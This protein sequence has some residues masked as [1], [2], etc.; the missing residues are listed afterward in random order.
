MRSQLALLVGAFTTLVGCSQAPQ[1]PSPQ[2]GEPTL[3]VYV[4]VDQLR[5]DLLDRYAAAFDGGFRRL[6]DEGMV[7]EGASHRHST[8]TT[9]VGHATLSTGVV[10]ARHGLNG[11]SWSERRPDGSLVDVY[12]V[13]DSTAPIV[14]LPG[15]PGRSPANLMRDGLADWILER[16]PAA[17]VVSLSAKDRAAIPMAG[18]ARGHVYWIQR[19][20]GRFVTSTHYRE[21]YPGWVADFNRSRMPL[22]LGDSVWQQSTPVGIREL[23]RP[24]PASYEGDGIHTTFPHVRSQETDGPMPYAQWNWSGG[25]P[26]PDR[27]VLELAEVAVEELE[28]GRRGT[29]DYLALSFSQTDYVG[30]GYGPLSQEQLDN[31]LRLDAVLGDLLDMLD[32]RVGPDRWVLGLSSDHGV[33]TTPEWLQHEGRGARRLELEDF[34]RI[35]ELVSTAEAGGGGRQEVRDRIAEAVGALDVVAQVYRTEE[36]KS[37]GPDTLAALFAAATVPGRMTGILGAYDLHLLFREAVLARPGTGTTHGSPYWYD[38]HV[39]FILRGPG[40]PA[41]RRSDVAVHTVDMA[42]ILAGLA[43]IPVPNDLDGRVPEGLG[44]GVP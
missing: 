18:R 27:A 5:G 44:R 25:T 19:E 26:A 33:M 7:F 11:N 41:V 1:S 38:R 17:R 39:P 21:A 29:V 16:D 12:A 37:E 31:L 15:V 32:R 42:P 24:D 40:I 20:E 13:A 8:T 3:V 34:R 30:H 2:I 6:M 14:G 28:L 10:P 43:G 9:A 23:A 35:R 22:L 36:L 4:V